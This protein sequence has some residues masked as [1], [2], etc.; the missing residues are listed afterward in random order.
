M[1]EVAAFVNLK[2]LYISPHN[3]GP[4]LVEAFGRSSPLK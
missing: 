3:I 2:D 1:L 4:D